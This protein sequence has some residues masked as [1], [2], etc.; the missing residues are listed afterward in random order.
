MTSPDSSAAAVSAN[1]GGCSTLKTT[2]IEA[3]TGIAISAPRMPAI[4]APAKRTRIAISGLTL[5]A[6]PY[7]SGWTTLVAPAYSGGS[8]RQSDNNGQWARYA[9][10]GRAIAVVMSANPT[11]VL[12]IIYAPDFAVRGGPALPM[13]AI[14]LT[15][16]Y[17][18]A[19]R[20]SRVDPCES[21]RN[22]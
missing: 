20:A 7:S 9:F 16:S 17:V 15:A 4:C 18:P 12:G 1:R 14:G 22:D 6:R 3:A 21:L 5:T 2:A 8:A 10:G 11:D 13:L 19:C